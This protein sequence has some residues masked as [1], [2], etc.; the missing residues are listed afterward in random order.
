MIEDND[1]DQ[2]EIDP[3]ELRR[4]LADMGM[5]RTPNIVNADNAGL[6]PI[7]GNSI[8]IGHVSEVNG[9]GAGELPGFVPTRHEL[10]LLVK[11][12][13]T[14]VIDFDF[15]FF[16]CEQWCSSGIRRRK[17][18]LRRIDRIAAFIGEDAVG[19]AIDEAYEEYGRQQDS[20]S[21]RV[22]LHG[23]EDEQRAL[24]AKF[25]AADEVIAREHEDQFYAS[26]LKFIAGEPHDIKPDT[27]GMGQAE[28][29]KMLVKENPAL[30][31][32]ENRGVL[33]KEIHDRFVWGH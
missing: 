23:T 19:R 22:Y 21:W 7:R 9:W 29:A 5:P 8:L 2:G 4:R 10:C 24:K 28:I 6:E 33:L 11:C 18:S 16:C 15:F 27:I 1:I 17:L 30:A 25:D 26:L 14:E 13:M 20:E 12:W 31:A 32:P 3:G